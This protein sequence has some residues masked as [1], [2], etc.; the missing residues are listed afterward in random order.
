MVN[1]NK[2]VM[3]INV[4]NIRLA[5]L[6]VIVMLF[7]QNS[8]AKQREKC[9][10]LLHTSEYVSSS[11]YL[12]IDTLASDEKERIETI[13]RRE[14]NE[15]QNETK[16][17]DLLAA[18][19]KEE[20]VK[21]RRAFINRQSSISQSDGNYDN[22]YSK[23]EKVVT[24]GIRGGLN[25]ASLQLNS[26]VNG[27]CSMVFSYHAGV[28][29]DF[30]LIKV[31]HLNLSVLFSEKGYKYENNNKSVLHEKTKAQF[32]SVP[33]QLALKFG[34]FQINA[35]GYFD[36][37]IGGKID[38]GGTVGTFEYF[39]AVNYGVTAGLGFNIGKHVYLGANYELGLSDYANRNI[40]ISFGVNF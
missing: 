24:F 30:R 3:T 18:K 20:Y 11:Q 12:V 19:E 7:I 38:Y 40:A 37:G 13:K 4:N 1:T 29:V 36:Y 28:N 5:F 32:I 34:F 39:S 8:D 2:M 10:Q 22:S 25:I 17:A 9:N 21:E 14:E 6:G 31:L 27:K 35:G 15:Q 16:E 33:L 23:K 26:D